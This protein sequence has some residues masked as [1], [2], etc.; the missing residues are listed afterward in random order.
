MAGVSSLASR[1]LGKQ[2]LK[3]KNL[4]HMTL[5]D[6]AP[7][8]MPDLTI[9]HDTCSSADYSTDI[10]RHLNQLQQTLIETIGQ[11]IFEH[12]LDNRELLRS[13]QNEF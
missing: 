11:P 12:I 10:H 13:R 6:Y 5:A 8:V 1:E 2:E 3:F 9:D 4:D 7:I